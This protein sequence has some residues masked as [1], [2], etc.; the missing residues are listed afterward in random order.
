[1]AQRL[2]LDILTDDEIGIIFDKCIS[3]LLT[4]GVV[5][6]HVPALQ[7][8]SKTG[9]D[10]DLE[11]KLVKFPVDIALD[12]LKLAPN[13]VVIGDKVL[14]DPSGG[15]FGENL[16]GTIMYHDPESL[17]FR[18]VRK[19]DVAE[20]AQLAHLLPELALVAYP[21]PADAPP[22]TVNLHAVV[23]IV[24][25]TDKQVVILPDS[26][27]D[28][29]YLFELAQVVSGSIENLKAN[30][31]FI[32]IIDVDSPFHFKT[33]DIEWLMQAGRYGQ[34]VQ[35]ANATIAGATAPVTLA[36]QVAL[37]ASE[38]LA[39]VVMSQLLNPGTPVIANSMTLRMDMR[40][41]RAMES[42]ESMLVSS[43]LAQFYK[44]K[45][46]I[47]VANS[48][49]FS[50]TYGIDFQAGL[51][52]ALGGAIGA[53]S[54]ADVLIGFGGIGGL[55]TSPVQLIL[56]DS[57]S[58]ML[59]RLAQG[60]KVDEEN[61][62]W[63]EILRIEPGGNFMDRPHTAKHCRESVLPPLFSN[64][65]IENWMQAGCKDMYARAVDK[66]RELKKVMKPRDLPADVLQELD[67][68]IKRADSQ[69]TG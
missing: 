57:L 68:I 22:S 10:V 53:I 26:I 32:P 66:Y 13:K 8:L 16:S 64:A 12:A 55:A 31:V 29:D 17:T 50:L 60:V 20:C 18:D 59:R 34:P 41:G 56:D 6:D 1:V 19:T 36:G 63:D 27:R 44:C 52:K 11:S 9:A 4:K 62:A 15:F 35:L 67:R 5:V 69:I 47:P 24:K 39:L 33:Q 43:A 42:M 25:N 38:M 2:V 23:E 46:N 61:L 21:V 51:E 7:Q 48:A 28:I 3:L 40:T 49:F 30:P 37:A 58:R 14:P 45:C 54:N 65:T